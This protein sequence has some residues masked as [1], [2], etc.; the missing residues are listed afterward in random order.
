VKFKGEII[1]QSSQFV[2]VMHAI[3]QDMLAMAKKR[4]EF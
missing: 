4:P 3:R 2:R 1:R